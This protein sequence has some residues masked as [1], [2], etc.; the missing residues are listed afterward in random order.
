[1]MKFCKF[2]IMASIFVAML[3]LCPARCEVFNSLEYGFSVEYPDGLDLNAYDT[4]SETG[5]ESP[6]AVKFAFPSSSIYI[7]AYENPYIE[8]MDFADN[9]KSEYE[10]IEDSNYTIVKI[11]DIKI[12]DADAVSLEGIMDYEGSYEKKKY[13]DVLIGNDEMIYQISCR[14]D[15]TDFAKENRT[16]FHD[17]I[18]SFQMY[19]INETVEDNLSGFPKKIVRA[20]SIWSSPALADIND[21]G[22]QEIIFG[23]NDNQLHALG[24]NGMEIDGFPVVVGDIIRSSPAV[25][26]IDGDGAPEIAV[27]CDDGMMYVFESNG[28]VAAGF[29]TETG[30]GISSS[31]ALA[32]IDGDGALE[33]VAGSLDRGIYAW[34][35]DGSIVCGYPEI[36]F[37]DIWSSA[38]I[39]DLNEDSNLDIVIGSR[40]Q[41][42]NLMEC[43]FTSN[44]GKI[45]G[46]DRSG[47]A[48]EGFPLEFPDEIG[49]SSPVL[50]DIDGDNET[51]IIFAATHNLYAK[52][53]SDGED[54]KGFPVKIGDAS[55]SESGIMQDSFIAVS[56]L[57]GDG[58][59]DIV[60][61]ATD[62]RLYVLRSDGSNMPGFPLQTGGYVRHVTLGDINGD[63]RQE[64]VGGSSDHR[65]HAWDLD[66]MELSGFP[67][68]TLD[69]IETAPTLG[70]L[71]GDG[72]LEL[73]VGSDD[74]RLYVWRISNSYGE[75]DWP[76]IR[77][78][79]QHM[80]VA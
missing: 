32:D 51:E 79:L 50:S 55:R 23:A 22:K 52:S 26:D 73:I 66:G 34:N 75:L 31:P 16:H 37:G 12:G 48:L 44:E 71:E 1:M 3:L 14:A 20:D 67:K 60:A 9:L 77:Q 21:D 42:N 30:S 72:T 69:E 65:V 49:Y 45:Y 80:P 4:T 78:N 8:L 29:P 40:K 58:R 57:D 76:M 70:D 74:S 6:I 5:M 13:R 38:A 24:L 61:G 17:L 41:C 62:G 15:I 33:I 18:N 27:G 39:G 68:V 43:I 56:D 35:S 53:I 11:G 10:E 59:E 47:N 28:T 63:G 46:L 2:C 36:T 54:I 7:G 64:I 25:D 19:S